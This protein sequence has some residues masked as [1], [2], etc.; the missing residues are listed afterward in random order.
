LGKN[1]ITA[2][3]SFDAPVLVAHMAKADEDSA[4]VFNKAVSSLL[5][6]ERFVFG[7][8]TSSK[9]V[10]IEDDLELPFV[11]L[12]NPSDEATPT[13]HG[14]FDAESIAKFALQAAS[15][16]LIGRFSLESLA[17][18]AD[19]AF[20]CSSLLHLLTLP[21]RFIACSH[22]YSHARRAT[23]TPT[24]ITAVGGETPRQP[25]IRNCRCLETRFPCW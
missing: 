14:P 22:I 20:L 24:C 11:A 5:K 15:A 9:L 8:T 17:A 23:E 3:T 13:Y 1:N 16:P 12:Y 21:D 6:E 4:K 10:G 2:L 25:Q 19:V 18:Y 7:K